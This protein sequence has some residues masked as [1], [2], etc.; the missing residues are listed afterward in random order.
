MQSLDQI[1]TTPGTYVLILKLRQKLRLLI[2][3]LGEHE[4][5]TGYYAY[6]GSAQGP[7]G[8]AGR[9]KSHLT[10]LP[11]KPPHWH[12]DH[13]NQQADITQIWWLEGTSNHECIWSQILASIGTRSVPN[14]GSSD[15]GCPGHLIWF[16]QPKKF[17]WPECMKAI[18]D[19]LR[20]IVISH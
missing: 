7:G 19:N 14:F 12:I 11:T 3:R 5:Q 9:L 18:A 15:C 13:L 16:P 2:G 4:F 8:L 20:K 1:P 6:V 10:L 17:S